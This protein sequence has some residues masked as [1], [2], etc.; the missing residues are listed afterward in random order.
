[1][2]RELLLPDDAEVGQK[3]FTADGRA[4]ER[5]IA[6][7]KTVPEIGVE[8]RVGQKDRAHDDKDEKSHE[9][10]WEEF[11]RC[12]RRRVGSIYFVVIGR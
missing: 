5:L 1:M 3:L 10:P 9:Q 11:G 7:Q 8:Q 2:W 6:K 4:A 12:C